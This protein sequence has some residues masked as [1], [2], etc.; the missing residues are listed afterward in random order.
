M[1]RISTPKIK[2]RRVAKP[3][4]IRIKTPNLEKAVQMQKKV[5]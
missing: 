2:P 1:R 3:R 4:D 5:K